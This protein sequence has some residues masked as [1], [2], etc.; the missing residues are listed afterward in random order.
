MTDSIPKIVFIGYGL[1]GDFLICLKSIELLRVQFPEAY[2]YYIGNKT[3]AQ[4]GLD[5][6]HINEIVEEDDE[7]MNYYTRK[8]FI[9]RKWD[10]LL[11]KANLRR[12]VRP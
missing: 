11:S 7:F 9:C 10:K 4:L 3:F 5:G 2:I 1:L 6:Y 8:D 12:S